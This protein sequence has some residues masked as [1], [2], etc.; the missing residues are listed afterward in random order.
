[1]T[2]P[3]VAGSVSPFPGPPHCVLARRLISPGAPVL[4][5]VRFHPDKEW[6]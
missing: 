5:R 2:C 3:Y 4:V 1:M 6:V